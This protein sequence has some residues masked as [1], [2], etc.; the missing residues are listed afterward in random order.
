VA[1]RDGRFAV[2]GSDDE[3]QFLVQEI[4]ASNHVYSADMGRGC[5]IDQMRA[6]IHLTTAAG[7]QVVVR[8]GAVEFTLIEDSI[9][10][11]GR[12]GGHE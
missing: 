10:R 3:G 4:S 2:R 12:D 9:H 6:V 11:R 7:N 1:E 5:R 8:S